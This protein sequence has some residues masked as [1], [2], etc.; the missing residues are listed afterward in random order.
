LYVAGI[1]YSATDELTVRRSRGGSVEDFVGVY[2]SDCLAFSDVGV[3]NKPLRGLFFLSTVPFRETGRFW[4]SSDGCIFSFS[5]ACAFDALS[6]SFLFTKDFLRLVYAFS[7][8]VTISVSAR[9][10]KGFFF[11][12]EGERDGLVEVGAELIHDRRLS[13]LEKLLA[14]ELRA[15]GVVGAVEANVDSVFAESTLEL[16][17]L[18]EDELL[19]LLSSKK[20]G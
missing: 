1:S 2:A 3:L 6:E 10:G 17:Y 14:I 19:L 8:G 13:F 12:G 11:G 7:G 20:S 5:C 16:W 9:V 18:V 4:E 15:R